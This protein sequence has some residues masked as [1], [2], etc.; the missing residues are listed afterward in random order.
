MLGCRTRLGFG[1][2]GKRGGLGSGDLGSRAKGSE[3]GVGWVRFRTIA[4]L[5]FRAGSSGMRRGQRSSAPSSMK[6]EDP[7]GSS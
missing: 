7:H 5:R 2:F 6:W 1:K 3:F 4:V